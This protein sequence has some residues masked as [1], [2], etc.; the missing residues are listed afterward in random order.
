MSQP[1]RPHRLGPPGSS[2]P[3]SE[4]PFQ[5]HHGV[6]KT[7]L[8]PP[9]PYPHLTQTILKIEV[10]TVLPTPM[11]DRWPALSPCAQPTPTPGHSP[12]GPPTVGSHQEARS[13]NTPLLTRFPPCPLP[14]AERYIRKRLINHRSILRNI[15]PC[16]ALRQLNKGDFF[17]LQKKNAEILVKTQSPALADWLRG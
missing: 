6:F 15:K 17:P 4:V 1:G 14:R 7:A 3:I 2:A 12:A 9:H 16:Q 5:S 8:P 13:R 11:P 10:S